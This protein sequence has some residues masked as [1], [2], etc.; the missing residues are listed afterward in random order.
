MLQFN[1]AQNSATIIVDFGFFHLLACKPDKIKTFQLERNTWKYQPDA[2]DIYKLQKHT[3]IME[4]VTIV[5]TVSSCILDHKLGRTLFRW[6]QI[7]CNFS[8]VSIVF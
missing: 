2:I 1:S 8:N 5:V 3:Y 4:S 7:K 6:A